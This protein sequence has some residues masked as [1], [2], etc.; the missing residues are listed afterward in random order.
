[1]EIEG[2]DWWGVFFFVLV[3]IAGSVAITILIHG[4]INIVLSQETAN[5]ICSDLTNESG[6]KAIDYNEGSNADLI[7][8]GELYCQIPSY[9]QTYLIRVG[10]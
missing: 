10:S 2:G 3:L 4:E 1:M 8:K 6:V 9:D 7:D 5:K